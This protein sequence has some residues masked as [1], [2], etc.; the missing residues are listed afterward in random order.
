MHGN[1]NVKFHSLFLRAEFLREF[2][3]L[4]TTW[5][6]I[7]YTVYFIQFL[8]Y[9]WGGNRLGGSKT[10]KLLQSYDTLQWIQS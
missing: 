10:K 1:M 3:R 5:H 9:T 8:H 7:L 6:L 4:L 2:C